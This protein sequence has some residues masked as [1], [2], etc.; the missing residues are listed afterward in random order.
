MLARL[1]GTDLPV[2]AG[3]DLTSR[4]LHEVVRPKDS[5]AIVGGSL[6]LLDQLRLLFPHVLFTQHIPPMGLRN[7]FAAQ[8]AAADFVLRQNARFIFI[9]VGS[10]QQ[11]MIAASV[12]RRGGAGGVAL[13][14]GAA[15]DFVAGLQRRAPRPVQL[16]GLEW[17]YRLC[18]DPRRMWRRYLVEGPRIFIL[19]ARYRNSKPTDEG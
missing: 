15:L 1:Q 4:L 18:R 8:E 2:V 13:C 7:D 16:L 11:E 12:Y 10:P 5:I 14:V 19:A 3:S 6:K 17:A 9:A